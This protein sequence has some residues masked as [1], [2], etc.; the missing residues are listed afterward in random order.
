MCASPLGNS[1]TT[2]AVWAVFLTVHKLT[3]RLDGFSITRS[4]WSTTTGKAFNTT[5][6]VVFFQQVI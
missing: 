6:F 1:D 2:V 3:N 5:K 4:S